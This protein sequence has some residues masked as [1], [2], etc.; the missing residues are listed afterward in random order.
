[1]DWLLLQ[2]ADSAFPVGGFAHSGG[3]EAALQLGG[4]HRADLPTEGTSTGLRSYIEM[5]AWQ[6]GLGAIPFVAATWDQPTRVPELDRMNDAFLLSAV[7]NRASR[8][9]GRVFLAT[10]TRVFGGSALHQLGAEARAQRLC[11]H[12]AVIFGAVM[13]HVGVSRDDTLGLFLH[14]AIRGVTSAAVRLGV[15]GPHEAQRLQYEVAPLLQTVL[16]SA[17]PIAP[18][19][20]SQPAPF[21]DLL[22]SV[23]DRLYSRLFQ[24]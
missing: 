10:C 15:V 23:Q 18:E 4:L 20:V 21:F 2:L 3:L 16:D 8:T 13:R 17:A 7:A 6:A 1:M 22:G 5:A 19:A 11:L 24:S 14:G 9:Q 12:Q